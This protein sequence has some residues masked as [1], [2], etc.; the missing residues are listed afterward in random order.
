MAYDEGLAQRMRDDLAD[1]TVAER[2]MFGGLAFL[3]GGHMVCGVHR[4]GAMLRVGKAAYDAALEVPGVRPMLFTGRPMAGMVDVEACTGRR[5]PARGA[6][7]DGHGGSQGAA[8]VLKAPERLIGRAWNAAGDAMADR[9][10]PAPAP[11][12]PRCRPPA[13]QPD[14]PADL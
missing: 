11:P 3:I 8:A 10:T 14:H 9:K 12:C 6:D 2:K 1:E 13:D 4:G 7:G 5:D